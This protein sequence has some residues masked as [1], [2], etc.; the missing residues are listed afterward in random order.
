MKQLTCEMC[1]STNLVKEDGVFVCQD[2][3]TKY[4]LEEAKKMMVEGTVEVTGTVKVDSSAQI[5]N[6]LMMAKNAYDASNMKEAESY[7]NKIIEIDPNNYEAWLLKGKAA[8]W[9]STVAKNRIEESANCFNKAVENAPED[10]A[11]DVKENAAKE[12]KKLAVALVSLSCDHYK[13]NASI[14]NANTIKNLAIMVQ[15]YALKMMAT[16][17]VKSDDFTSEIAVKINNGVVGGYGDIERD[18]RGVNG[19]YHPN[20]NDWKQ[21]KARMYTAI[22]LLKYAI[23]IDKNPTPKDT[24]TR[25]SNIIY[26]LQ[27]I[28]KSSYPYLAIS[29]QTEKTIND[30]IDQIMECHS[31]IKEV[32]PDYVIPERPRPS[33]QGARGGCYVATAVYGSY[34]CPQVW[35]LRRYRDYTLAETWHGRVFIHIY[36]AISPTLVKWFGESAWFKKLWKGKLDCLVAKLQSKG[37]ESTPYEDRRW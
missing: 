21:Y 4:S 35:T 19:D 8:G 17:G 16:C 34:D 13:K 22:D 26:G 14:D 27:K 2:C 29:A 32:N 7:C 6:Y 36:Y 24:E 3:G 9:Q 10:K 30:L 5:A 28:E 37:V 11:E 20:M 15:V 33:Y 25:Y 31:K 18:F 23:S 12:F 1:G